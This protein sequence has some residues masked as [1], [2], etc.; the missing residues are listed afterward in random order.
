M[1]LATFRKKCSKCF[2]EKTGLDFHKDKRKKKYPQLQA[3]CIECSRIR[4][5]RR[6]RETMYNRQYH[7]KTR[8]N[9][10]L[11]DYENKKKAQQDCCEI[12]KKKSDK[13][14]VDHDHDT[15]EIRDLLCNACNWG[16]GQFK[17]NPKYLLAAANYLIKHNKQNVMNGDYDMV[18][19]SIDRLFDMCYNGGSGDPQ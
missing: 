12:C 5:K 10:S 16:L 6:T 8:Y 13:L 9:I 14:F 11:E 3:E 4:N 7:F 17:D 18:E 1:S 2:L 19:I 15:N